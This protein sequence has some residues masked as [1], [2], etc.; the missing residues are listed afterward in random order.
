MSL[1]RYEQTFIRVCFD[2]AP[3]EADLELL[4][5]RARYLLYRDM[6][7]SRLRELAESALPR[8]RTA[9][10][11]ERFAT[12]FDEHL[13]VAPPRSRYIR[14]V[15]LPFAAWLVGRV[16]DDA[17]AQP[18]LRD[19]VVLERARWQAVWSDATGEPAVGELDFDRRPVL[20]PVTEL[21]ALE[22]AVHADPDGR[23]AYEA[24]P[25]WL[26]VHRRPGDH[27]VGTFVV[28]A[29]TAELFRAWASGDE[30]LMASVLRVA[31]ARGTTVDAGFIDGLCTVLSD[32][33]ERGILLGSR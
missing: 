5:D 21:L 19:L 7:R 25:V 12:L 29:V 17:G 8:T 2:R 26:I 14:E 28:N 20:G 23:G 32:F 22:H 30:T 4:G 33:L 13:S 16:A 31:A 11:A 6:V 15:A 27:V 9:L 3:S 1:D 10:G 24:R 18:W